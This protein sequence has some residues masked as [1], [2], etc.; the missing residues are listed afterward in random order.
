M[1]SSIE[2]SANSDIKNPLTMCNLSFRSFVDDK[3]Y[4]SS[5]CL[6][7]DEFPLNCDV[8]ISFIT[9]IIAHHHKANEK[10]INVNICYN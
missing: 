10:I 2:N 6:L 3:F 9:F 8:F 7:C 5:K 1:R 4:T